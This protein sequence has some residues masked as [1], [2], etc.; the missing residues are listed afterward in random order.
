[1]P[2]NKTD[3]LICAHCQRSFTGSANQHYRLR[4]VPHAVAYCSLE[5]QRI[6]QQAARQ[7]W[8]RPPKGGHSE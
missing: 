1:M 3:P 5:C 4:R 8:L 2:T 7:R 6:G